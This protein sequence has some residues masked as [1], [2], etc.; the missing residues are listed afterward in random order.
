V[1][2]C[3]PIASRAGLG[4]PA[5]IDRVKQGADGFPVMDAAHRFGERR[6]Y[7]QYLE[8]GHA[9]FGRDRDSVGGDDFEHVAPRVEAIESAAGEQAMGASD[10]Y[11][12]GVTL[13][14]PF[15]ERPFP[16]SVGPSR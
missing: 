9:F 14:Q 7:R 16:H 11:R 4:G 1:R 6:R 15:E 8:L 13:A 2:R 12:A 10:A 5:A 3:L